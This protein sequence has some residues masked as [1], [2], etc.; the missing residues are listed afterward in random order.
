MLIY[1]AISLKMKRSQFFAVICLLGLCNECFSVTINEIIL[2]SSIG[3]LQSKDLILTKMSLGVGDEF[4]PV[5]LLLVA[6][7]A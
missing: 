5:D 4:S 1:S 2:K 7:I 6:W 3:E